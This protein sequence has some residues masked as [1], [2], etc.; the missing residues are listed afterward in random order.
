MKTWTRNV[1]VGLA[2]AA[3]LQVMPQAEAV[4]PPDLFLQHLAEFNWIGPNGG[5]WQTPANWTAPT[6]PV[7]Y[8]YP[9][10]TFPNDPGRIDDPAIGTNEVDI[11]P[12]VGANL[13][14]T[15]IGDR[16][17]NIAS[18]D[19][20][21]ASLKLGG[22]GAAVTT[23]VTASGAFRLIFEN[24]ELNDTVT[25]PGDPEADPEIEPEPIYGFNQ[26]RSLIWSTGTAGVGKINRIS[27]PIQLNDGVD[28]EGDRDLH[29]YG[30]IHEGPIDRDGVSVGFEETIESSISSL[31]TNN[32]RLYIHGN[33]VSVGLA[34][35]GTVT[36]SD[37]PGGDRRIG[38]NVER[39]IPVPADPQNPPDEVPRQGTV[40]VLGNIQGDGLVTLGTL[41]GNELPLGNV[42]IRSDNAA[43][44][45]RM[46]VGRGNVV[47]GHNNA[48]GGP[49]LT[50]TD[51]HKV[52]TGGPTQGFGANFISDSDDRNVPVPVDIAQW[53]IVRGAS[54][55]AGLEGIGDHSLTFSGEIAQTNTRGWINLLPAGK[56]LTF[57]GPIYPS[58]K[59]ENPPG[60]GR[61]MTFDGSGKTVITG[62]I[63]N[64]LTSPDDPP[65]VADK[66]SYLRVRGSGVVVVDG[67]VF[68]SG[69]VQTGYNDSDYSGYTFVQGANL[70]FRAETDI[71][72]GAIIST[73]GAVGVDTGV[74]G[75]TAFLN[76]LN[77]SSF[78]NQPVNSSPF[79]ITWGDNAGIYSTY[80]T[81]GLMLG[82]VGSNEYTQSLNFNSGDL[83]K[84]ANMSLAAHEGGSTYTGTITPNTTVAVNPNTYQ[85]GGGSG[86]LTLPNA[87][88]L[89]GA[90][91][92]L[93]TN[94]GTVRLTANNNYTGTTRILRK[95]TPS[96][97]AQALANQRSNGGNDDATAS[98]AVSSTLA[99]TTLANGGAASGIGS[100][101][102]AAA[103]LVIQGGALKYEGA[104]A[105]TDRLFT[106]GTSGATVDASGSGAVN[107]TNTG[108]LAISVPAQRNGLIANVVPGGNSSTI[109]GQPSHT[110]ATRREFHTEDLTI[111]MRVYTSNGD[112]TPPAGGSAIRIT[113]I[114]NRE[115][116]NA[117]QPEL[118]DSEEDNDAAT[119]PNRWP[120]YTA[121]GNVRMIQFGPAPARFLSLTG[122][123]T[124]NNTLA[125]LIANAAVD[126]NAAPTTPE[127]AAAELAAGYGTVGINKTG[128]GKWILT[129][130]NTYSGATNVQAGTLLING[131][132]TG[133]SLTT[134]SSGAS[135][136]GTGQIGGGLT[137]LEGSTFTAA[138]SGGA[139]DP[140]AILGN[141]DLSAIGN[142][143]SVTGAGSP[144]IHTLLTYGGTLT[145]TFESSPGVTLDY[146]TAGMIKLM[147]G[148][149][150]LVGDYN[151][152]G[153]VDAA[154]YSVWRDNLGGNGSTL[155]ANR[156]PLNGGVVSI[157][158]YNSWKANF[159]MTGGSG[160]L[161][162]AAVPEPG[163]CVLLGIALAGVGMIRRRS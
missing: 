110:T 93:V 65:T 37:G 142:M 1:A 157:A 111:G 70:H 141:L 22:T 81:G 119:L 76:R 5:A 143:L 77:N 46:E 115:V 78:P 83:T 43:F 91:N 88:Q 117:G 98:G 18:S 92:L 35:D 148:G 84:A 106:V 105:S 75:N 47:I 72:D 94:G 39:G 139:I 158:D 26:G 60:L 133:N 11:F 19:I 10:P 67:R 9:I 71:G 118:I 2:L 128:T 24:A 36:S 154:D 56:T 63:H 31:L 8:P 102:N 89:T 125:P 6:F 163:T 113:S 14:G 159:G 95:Y 126:V 108:A 54:G 16:T 162:G 69:G 23:D 129:G 130:N 138:F 96:N 34:A 58:V 86:P 112:F 73:A 15:L 87:N 151:N 61:A 135:F 152:N 104:A 97:E 38:I 90:N 66:I 49:K 116:L 103:N 124:G 100:S 12:V 101:T 145:G 123:N 50:P 146:S 150:A 52:K 29:I 107:F 64:Q 44:T 25:N 160:S 109:F 42:I 32:G 121:S 74:T 57:S 13:S 80:S 144:G 20:T 82:N 114:S 99:V 28:V 51:A 68:D 59:G 48:L 149:S 7:G 55:M 156:D 132:Q 161:A 147:V 134:V 33:I 155:G 3:S 79:F 45:G 53:A 62:G 131:N 120:G 136:G 21:V 4:D 140:F 27:A 30:N 153:A 122:S 40:E 17:V 137:M 41:N 85:L 127:I